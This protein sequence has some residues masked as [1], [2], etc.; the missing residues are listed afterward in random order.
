MLLTPALQVR[1]ANNPQLH[2]PDHR[3]GRA[4]NDFSCDKRFVDLRMTEVE[5][6]ED[7]REKHKREERARVLREQAPVIDAITAMVQL[8]AALCS[9]ICGVGGRAY[10]LG[11]A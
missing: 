5:I 7:R 11:L 4:E 8:P 1:D 10:T 3:R 9:L 2:C 6:G